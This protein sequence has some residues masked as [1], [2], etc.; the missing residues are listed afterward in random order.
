MHKIKEKRGETLLETLASILIFTFSSIVMLTMLSAAVR[1]NQRAKE[2][3]R[4]HASQML[5]AE[6][7][8]AP[9]TAQG[10]VLFTVNGTAQPVPVELYRAEEGLYSYFAAGEDGE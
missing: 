8:E 3:D 7:A 1:L 5:T 2:A 10:T 4:V 9:S 6:M